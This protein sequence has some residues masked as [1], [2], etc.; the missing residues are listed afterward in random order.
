MKT[1]SIDCSTV[2]ELSEVYL[3][4]KLPQDEAAAVERHL[5]A[6]DPCRE[7]LK[8]FREVSSLLRYVDAEKRES[9]APILESVGAM[10]VL[11]SMP[12]WGV[13]VALHVLVIALAGLISM[14][15]SLPPGEQAV[16]TITELSPRPQITAEVE[17]AKELERSALASKHETPPTDHTSP[18]Q[19]NVVIP[20]DILARAEI[21]DHFETINPDRP[22]T[23]SA[24]GNPES[25]S[26]HKDS[27]D[28]SE[29]GG[30]GT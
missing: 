22:D 19:C 12:W 5:A 8:C 6:C 15:I 3:D 2:A 28:D 18:E 16:V 4:G 25:E 23:Q 20:P 13:S 27:G 14:A 10:G 30:G 17:K 11:S 7:S 9:E 24:F 21:G 26:F 1:D 29:A